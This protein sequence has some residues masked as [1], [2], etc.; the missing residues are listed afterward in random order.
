LLATPGAIF[1]DLLAK[2]KALKLARADARKRLQQKPR[3][4]KAKQMRSKNL[5][6]QKRYSYKVRKN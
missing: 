6:M 1:D 3:Q 2:L 4:R 5:P